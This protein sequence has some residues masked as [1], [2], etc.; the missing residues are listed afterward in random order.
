MTATTT[1]IRRFSRTDRLFHLF[2]M[3]TFIIQ[4][5]TGFGRLFITTGWGKQLIAFFGGYEN[6]LLIHEWVGILM[7]AGFV[8]HTFYLLAR[9]D[10]KKPV[11]SIFGP[12][13]L[14][15]N[16]QDFKDFGNRIRWLFG[17][18]PQP[19]LNRWTYWEKFDYWAVYWGLPLLAI[20]GLMLMAP[21][22]TSRFVPGWSLNIAVLL[23]RAEAIL[24]VTYIFIVH[25]FVGH[26][27]PSSFP[28]NEAMFSG[29]V[30][31]AEAE[32]EKPVWIERLRRQGGLDTP[33]VVMPA[34][35]FRIVYFL[36][37]YM[38]LIIGIY[39][40]ISGLINSRNIILH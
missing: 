5:A 3:L 28:M 19:A 39:L 18:G 21:M 22:L 30:S 33:K 36:F 23:H 1:H 35:W 38:I 6:S 14:V 40:L 15:P 9:V 7:L 12:D 16:F 11:Q 27:R 13:S 26:L 20:T 29:N 4:T 32:K 31:V 25:F 34:P 17:F 2:L 37:G 10:W 24:A 8:V